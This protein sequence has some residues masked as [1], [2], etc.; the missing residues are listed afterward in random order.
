MRPARWL[1]CVCVALFGCTPHA[2]TTTQA[3]SEP[4]VTAY[5]RLHP[6][7]VLFTMKIPSEKH[8][9]EW[10]D[11]YGS[12]VVVESGSW[13]SRIL[14]DAH[15]VADAKNLVATIG[16]G[17]HA[18]AH[19]VATTGEAED[20]AIVDVPLKNQPAVKLGSIAR[21]RPGT[22]IGVLGYPI[23][24]AFEDEHL[25]RT[26]SLYTGRVAS[27]RK[28]ALEIDVPIIPGESGGPVFDA[29]TGEVIGIAESRFDEERAIGFATPIDTA[30]RFLASHPRVTAARR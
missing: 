20:L 21:I 5:E 30:T 17:P 23:P 4:Y 22:P 11:A 12:G 8:P 3:R 28:G 24:D 26:V 10:D 25:G 13:G 2:E 14:T 7:V 29:T 27:V 19:V 6:S 16:D 1:L 18:P 9:G 15:V